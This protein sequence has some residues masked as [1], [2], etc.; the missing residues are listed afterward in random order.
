MFC[1]GGDEEGREYPPGQHGMHRPLA[2]TKMDC[3]DGIEVV[4]NDREQ[5]FELLKAG[6]LV[7]LI[8]FK[9]RSGA[10]A[11]IH[12]EIFRDHSGQGLAAVLVEGALEQLDAAGQAL[13]PYCPYVRGYLGKHPEWVRLVP[14]DHRAQFDL[15]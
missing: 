8:D 9:P 1:S 11:L 4:R 3:M 5:R 10:V 12:T 15:T 13:L 6:Q 7:G 2:E 14:A